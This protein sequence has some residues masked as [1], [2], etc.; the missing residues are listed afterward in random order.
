MLRA[1]AWA[2][3]ETLVMLLL[4]RVDAADVFVQRR[5][6]GLVQRHRLN[7][8]TTATRQSSVA[9]IGSRG[10]TWPRA[11]NKSIFSS[12]VCSAKSRLPTSAYLRATA[13]HAWVGRRMLRRGEGMQERGGLREGERSGE[14]E[15][16]TDAVLGAI[17]TDGWVGVMGSGIEAG[18][19]AA[20][21]VRPTRARP[22]V[23]CSCARARVIVSGAYATPRL[24]IVFKTSG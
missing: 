9:Q 4:E 3:L 17:R 1:C 22:R 11:T 15:T 13:W 8:S 23:G 24:P 19:A 12:S 20:V 6:D 14:R 7:D 10:R 21:C 18:L 5:I 16:R 2:A